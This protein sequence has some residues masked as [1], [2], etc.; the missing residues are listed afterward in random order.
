MA[1]L[2]DIMVDVD[3]ESTPGYCVGSTQK[4]D[5]PGPAIKPEAAKADLPTSGDEGPAG[6]STKKAAASRGRPA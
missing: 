5:Q 2:F 3:A 4:D 1:R 6:A